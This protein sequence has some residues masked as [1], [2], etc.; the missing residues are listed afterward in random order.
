MFGPLFKLALPYL[1]PVA[2]RIVNMGLDVLERAIKERSKKKGSGNE[3]VA[4]SKGTEPMNPD[5]FWVKKTRES[6]DKLREVNL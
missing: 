6:F 2:M 5:E 4:A 1:I 3:V